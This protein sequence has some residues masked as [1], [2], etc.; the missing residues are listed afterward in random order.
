MMDYFG[1]PGL[2][3]GADF[4]VATTVA[5]RRRRA[6]AS[7]TT[8]SGQRAD[9]SVTTMA[10]GTRL[11]PSGQTVSAQR[12]ASGATVSAQRSSGGRTA[13]GQRPAASDMAEKADVS[14]LKTMVKGHHAK[15]DRAHKATQAEHDKLADD[16]DSGKVSGAAKATATKK[17]RMLAGK[18]TALFVRRQRTKAAAEF[19]NEADK[20]REPRKREAFRKAALAVMKSPIEATKGTFRGKCPPELAGF[21]S[22]GDFGYGGS[23]YDGQGVPQYISPIAQDVVASGLRDSIQTASL[24]GDYLPPNTIAV[25]G[26]ITLPG[27]AAAQPM[28]PDFVPGLRTSMQMPQYL[29]V[30]APPITKMP[31]PNPA[32]PAAAQH[33]LQ[34]RDDGLSIPGRRQPAALVTNRR[35]AMN[36]AVPS[37]AAKANGLP[38]ALTS[39]RQG[40]SVTAPSVT[41]G[42][43]SQTAGTIEA[44]P[45]RAADMGWLGADVLVADVAGIFE[46][47]VM[48]AERDHMAEQMAGLGNVSL[49]AM[50][51]AQRKAL[52]KI[53][54]RR[55]KQQGRIQG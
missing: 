39:P 37:P 36:T 6:A 14:A 20:Q 13:S 51:P 52:Q 44:T 50:S 8:A 2:G 46:E 4:G 53:E 35:R 17:R 16:I 3:L 47:V 34:T 12:E 42:T 55:A 25:P 38:A 1:I 24:P 33:P 54:Q 5:A 15:L 28:I 29:P 31:A 11:P 22:F 9:A 41:P 18:S 27:V 48:A 10:A 19:L 23:Y 32:L 40:V 45:M 26:G 43:G 7:S 21:G 30:T 49:G